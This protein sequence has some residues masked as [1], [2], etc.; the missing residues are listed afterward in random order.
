MGHLGLYWAI[1]AVLEASWD[2]LG[3]HIGAILG[4]LGAILAVLDIGGHIGP[5]WLSWRRLGT[6]LE[7]ILAVLEGSFVDLE[8]LYGLSVAVEALLGPSWGPLGPS[9]GHLGG[10]LGD[11]G[12][13]L[14][15]LGLLEG[16]KEAHP[17]NYQIL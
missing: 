6:V 11:L 3:R 15:R 8:V 17:K 4:F 12:G 14:G 9:W 5:S 13:P 1:L 10:L 7:A 2:R 16:P